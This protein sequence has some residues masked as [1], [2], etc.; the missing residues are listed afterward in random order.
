MSTTTA[1][2]VPPRLTRGRP[3]PLRLSNVFLPSVADWMKLEG[4]TL[5][6]LTK[7]SGVE[8]LARIHEALIQTGTPADDQALLRS[9]KR[10]LAITLPPDETLR[11]DLTQAM[12]GQPRALLSIG[13]IGEWTAFRH[14]LAG[15]ANPRQC[16]CIDHAAELEL[17]SQVAWK[18]LVQGNRGGAA[19]L[20][21]RHPELRLYAS[22]TAIR[23]LGEAQSLEETALPRLAMVCEFLLAQVARVQV[24]TDLAHRGERDLGFARLLQVRP[25][26]PGRALMQWSMQRLGFRSQAQWLGAVDHVTHAVD[27]STLKRWCSGHSFPTSNKLGPLIVAAV[28]Q[29]TEATQA[30]EDELAVFEAWFWAARRFAQLV[31][32]VNRALPCLP[33]HP[34]LLWSHQTAD[35]WLHARLAHWCRHWQETDA[36]S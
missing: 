12:T 17:A 20:V 27:E 30:K 32:L 33:Q 19:R 2:Q 21:A 4:L 9:L 34:Q 11:A 31:I 1:L 25:C 10:L 35:A 22:D 18:D 29:G 36:T 6:E 23:L 28:R 15:H 5:R 26:R 16:I 3:S 8:R 24:Q 13:V 7:A 14:G